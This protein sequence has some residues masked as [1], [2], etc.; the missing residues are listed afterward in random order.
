MKI[1][2]P[3]YDYKLCNGWKLLEPNNVMHN[4][5]WI[6][7]SYRG[8]EPNPCVH[9]VRGEGWRCCTLVWLYNIMSHTSGASN[10]RLAVSQQ[11]GW[12]VNNDKSWARDLQIIACNNIQNRRMAR[13]LE[14]SLLIKYLPHTALPSYWFIL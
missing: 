11:A 5:L 10:I 6:F 7:C 14:Q 4:L 9:H 2:L 1:L 13:L 12:R 8:S 3:N